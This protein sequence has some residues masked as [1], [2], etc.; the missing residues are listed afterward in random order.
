MRK[1]T[2]LGAVAMLVSASVAL[3]AS[4][5]SIKPRASSLAQAVART[6]D[7][8]TQQYAVDLR[9][10]KDKVAYALHAS[11]VVAPGTVF[12]HL[13]LGEVKQ[14]DGTVAPGS[15]T[16]GLID[17]PFLYEHAPDGITVGSVQWLRLR[18][19]S[20]GP[21]H[22]ALRG[23]HGMTATPLMHV[24]DEA[25]AH[26]V[27]RDASVFRGSVAYDDPIVVTAL[28]PLTAGLQFRDLRVTA[29]IGP[30]G[31]VR[32]VRLT[33]HTSDRTATLLVNARLFAFGRPV[34]ITPPAEGTF[35]DEQLLHLS[36]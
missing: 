35:L 20:L 2:L 23:M 9:I 15:E 11:S 4:G 5:H 6:A 34:H 14:A 21:S 36:D 26:A 16:W 10:V 24:L 13:A 33:G 3:A 31:L 8:R 17:G 30:G 29:W 28:Q 22:P 25:R 19:A 1:V 12:V 18:I 27:T 32:R 7:V